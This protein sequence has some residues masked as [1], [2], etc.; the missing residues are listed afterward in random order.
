MP[1]YPMAV[2]LRAVP[3]PPQPGAPMPRV[4]IP[5]YEVQQTAMAD[6][7]RPRSSMR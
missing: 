4:R 5:G 3:A 2:T 1:A 6:G 7:F